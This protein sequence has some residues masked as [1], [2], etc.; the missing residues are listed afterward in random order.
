MPIPN[1]VNYGGENESGFGDV[2]GMFS[3]N[4]KDADLLFMVDKKLTDSQSFWNSTYDLDNVR[5]YNQMRWENKNLEVNSSGP[6][7]DFQVPYRDNRIFTS[8]ETLMG[9]LAA[10]M[11]E[12]IVLEAFDTDASRELAENYGQVLMRWADEVNLVGQFQQAI[13]HLLQGYRIGVIKWWWDSNDG[14]MKPDGSFCGMPKVKALRPDRVVIGEKSTDSA[15]VPFIAEYLSSTLDE[16]ATRFPAK[17]AELY[18]QAGITDDQYD[19]QKL[20]REV[21]YVQS[22]FTF[23]E[24]NKRKEGVSWTLGKNIVLDSGINPY[25]NYTEAE[26]TNIHPRPMKPYCL[27]NFLNSGKWALDDTSLTEQAA[28]LQDVLE[29]RGRQIVENAD[30]ANSTKV[31]NI[32]MI[33]STAVERYIGDPNQSILVKGNVNEAFKREPPQ[34]LPSYVLQDKYDA[35]SEIDNI[36]GTHAPLRGEKTTSPT[37]GQE[38]LSQRSDLGRLEVFSQSLEYAAN[39]VYT[40]VTQ[41]FKVFGVEEHM[42]RFLGPTGKTA[43]YKFHRDKIEDGIEIKIQHGSMRPDDVTMD[44]MQAME[45]AKIGGQIDPLTLAEKMHWPKARELANRMISFAWLPDKY[46]KEVLGQGADEGQTEVIRTIQRIN[47]GRGVEPKADASRDYV[48][49]YRSYVSSPA[50]QQLPP[51]L[52]QLHLDHLKAT[53]AAVKGSLGG[54]K[55]GGKDFGE[56]EAKPNIFK[57]L[58]DIILQRRSEAG[59]PEET[60]A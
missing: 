36:F 1:Q 38:V 13:R 22:W 9:S 10:K 44:K 39:C 37:L 14:V 58:R 30:Q 17:R 16:L 29:K 57:K 26:G 21:D 33:N 56:G 50:F 20:N 27:L 51:Q 34:L 4:M 19:F 53:L 23:F 6:L 60:Y 42:T 2:T 8:V 11:P 35:R 32:N 24:D 45:I 28:V 43:F 55:P 47:S 54:K 40:G 52:Q 31:F 48:A 15:D 12:P 7:Y 59:P 25:F 3:L 46:I 49:G 5:K 41:L 18:R